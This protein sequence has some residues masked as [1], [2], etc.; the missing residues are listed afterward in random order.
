MKPAVPD[1][2]SL[3]SHCRALHVQLRVAELTEDDGPFRDAIGTWLMGHTE[4]MDFGTP[5]VAGNRVVVDTTIHAECRYLQSDGSAFRCLAHGFRGAVPDV[6]RP[7]EKPF[8]AADGTVTLMQ[9]DRVQALTLGSRAKPSRALPT[10]DANPCAG[11]P[12]RTAD[13][14]EG[15]AC[16]RDLTLEVIIP[17]WDIEAETLLE[18][19][20]P[21]YVCKTERVSEDIVECEVISACGYLEADGVGCGLH[22]RV[23]PDGSP[24]KPSICSDWPDL[25]EDCDWHPGCRLVAKA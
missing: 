19:R 8:V 1:C 23:R 14:A 16:C 7:A 4:N 22:D 15:A 3:G 24:A 2:R 11:A 18:T 6:R 17:A 25:D 9:D 10:L 5:R 21:P 20:Q 13:N 12:C